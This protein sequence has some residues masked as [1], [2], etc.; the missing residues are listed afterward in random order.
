MT[1]KLVETKCLYLDEVI[2][3]KFIPDSA[4]SVPKKAILC[5]NNETLKLFD[6]ETGNTNLFTG[7]KDII[8]CLDVKNDLFITGS[9][10]NEIRLWKYS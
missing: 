3:L 1:L 10:D 2:D 6:L 8:L 4:S 7:H 9:K 5:S